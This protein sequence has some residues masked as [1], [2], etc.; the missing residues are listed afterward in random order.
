VQ[1]WF[2]RTFDSR[3]VASATSGRGIR[4]KADRRLDVQR[5]GRIG[6]LEPLVS[7]EL[8][9]PG[10]MN[11][12]VLVTVLE[13]PFFVDLESQLSWLQLAARGVP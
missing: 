3:A 4:L 10:E 8:M 5:G 13:T 1:S 11:G 6:S 12:S 2:T 9:A 7:A